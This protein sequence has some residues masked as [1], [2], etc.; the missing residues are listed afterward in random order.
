[1]DQDGNPIRA[2]ELTPQTVFRGSSPGVEVGPYLSQF[3]LMG[4]PELNGAGGVAKGRIRY[5]VLQ[6]DQRVP[7][8]KPGAD[9]MQ[10]LAGYVDVQ[11]GIKPPQTEDV[12]YVDQMGNDAAGATVPA[13]RF[14]ST[15]RDLATYVHFDALYEAYLNACL[16]LLGMGTPADP[17]CDHLSGTGA[18]AGNPDTRR[19][20]GGFAFY[21]G[22]HILTLVT[23]VATRALK[24]VRFQKFNNH[25]RLRPEAL[26]HRIEL[27]R[28]NAL[29]PL[30]VPSALV[31]DVGDYVR[32]W[33]A[34]AVPE[35]ARWRRSRR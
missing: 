30:D 24:A 6:I 13:R 8:A 16:I 35:T 33:T 23:E 28:R 31:Q 22:P 10:D 19:N 25:I 17:A 32:R 27:V 4:S 5:G 7:V 1:M 34:T 15:P 20:A 21:G 2:P 11:R 3:L 29:A 18:A 12:V 9:H 26:A 14:I